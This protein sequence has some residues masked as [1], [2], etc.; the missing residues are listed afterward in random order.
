MPGATCRPAVAAAEQLTQV[1]LQRGDSY[2]LDNGIRGYQ[3]EKLRIPRNVSLAF[4]GFN[5]QDAPRERAH[6]GGARTV[7]GRAELA[8][9]Q[10]SERPVPARVRRSSGECDEPATIAISRHH[11]DLVVA[12]DRMY[13]QALADSGIGVN[14]DVIA[15]R[16][17]GAAAAGRQARADSRSPGE[18]GAAVH[19]R[20]KLNAV[21]RITVL[22]TP[23]I[24]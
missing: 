22:R 11:F 24:K 16:R 18:A 6:S 21:D 5:A 8:H 17:A 4:I 3:Q 19:V 15:V 9:V 12:N 10:R 1:P 14:N 7:Q 20:R 23:T 13:A 2:E